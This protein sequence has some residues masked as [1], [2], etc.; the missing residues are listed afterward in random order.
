M[1]TK[2]NVPFQWTTKCLN[3]F[4]HRKCLLASPPLLAYSDFTSILVD[5]SVEG[6]GAI[7]EQETNTQLLL[8]AYASRAL[9]KDKTNYSVTE[10]EKK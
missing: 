9:S 4:E 7:L 3:K 8:V 1:L 6:L 5:T 2:Q 10:L